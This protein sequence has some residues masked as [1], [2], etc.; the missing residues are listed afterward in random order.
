MRAGWRPAILDADVAG[1]VRPDPDPIEA[2][3]SDQTPPQTSPTPP[4]AKRLYRSRSMHM[5]GGVC[6]GLAAYFGVGPTLVRVLAVASILLPGPSI[7]AYLVM[8]IIVPEEPLT[9]T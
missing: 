9:T 4:P 2:P 3:M 6:G 1:T 8:W 7:I 5:L